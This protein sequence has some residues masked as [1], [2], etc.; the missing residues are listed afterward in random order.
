MTIPTFT[1][2]LAQLSERAGKS[3]VDLWARE[4]RSNISERKLLLARRIAANNGYAFN[5]GV[6]ALQVEAFRATGIESGLQAQ[7]LARH[8]TDIHRIWLGLETIVATG[9][10][11]DRILQLARSESLQAGQDG[12]GKALAADSRT[13]G[14]S[15]ALEADP[16]S[17]C[18][19]WYE[20]GRVF[21]KD[22]PMAW[23]VNCKCGKTP[24][25]R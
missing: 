19:E 10:V 2:T 21:P 3:A 12:Y 17:L 11:T 25:Y 23:H 8:S 16:C 6:I 24:V 14:W 15:R 13:I 7:P 9:D 20:G 18:E 1:D 4:A 5:Q 22:M